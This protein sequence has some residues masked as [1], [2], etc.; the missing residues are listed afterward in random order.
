MIFFEIMN[1]ELY[2]SVVEN[3]LEKRVK[4]IKKILYESTAP[5]LHAREV[6]AQSK[7]SR[8][9]RPQF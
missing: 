2:D 6:Y 1:P 4:N 8:L 7:V 5:R 3:R 9:L